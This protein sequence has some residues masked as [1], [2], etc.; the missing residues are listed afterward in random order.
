MKHEVFLLGSS[1]LG[2][3]SRYV[4]SM[5]RVMICVQSI[6]AGDISL[7]FHL[8]GYYGYVCVL[9]PESMICVQAS[10]KYGPSRL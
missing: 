6:Q 9:G 10:C 4:C 3:Q 5:F 7:W 2:I 1:S 8:I